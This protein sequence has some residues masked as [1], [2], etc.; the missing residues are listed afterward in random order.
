[1]TDERTLP[2]PKPSWKSGVLLTVGI[3]AGMFAVGLYRGGGQPPPAAPKVALQ[4]KGGGATNVDAIDPQAVRTRAWSKIVPQLN[5]VDELAAERIDQTVSDIN[6]FFVERKKGARPL[7]QALLGMK[8]KWQVV[9]AKLHQL[10]PRIPF[11]QQ[12]ADVAFVNEKIG[13]FIFTPDDARKAIEGSISGY[14]GQLNEMEDRLLIRIRADLS[15]REFGTASLIPALNTA[16]TLRQE[17]NALVKDLAKAASRDLGPTL[18]HELAVLVGSDV[19]A[20][21]AVRVAVAVATRLGVSAGILSAGAASSWATFGV[22]FVAA[23]MVDLSL[24]WLEKLVGYDPESAIAGKVE[25][26]LDRVRATFIDGDPEAR[27]IY[28]KLRQ[29]E[30]GQGLD[31]ARRE[32]RDA[33]NSIERSGNLGIRSELR[34]LHEGRRNLR[35]EAIRELIFGKENLT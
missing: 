16:E 5:Q 20:T 26:T 14:V 2:I 27:Q 28:L 33:A 30:N 17:Y 10:N 23:V 15:D 21:I 7:A 35:R 25:E 1:M 11:A 29:L 3:L 12:D 4:P 19:A 6:D 32:F 31:S 18:A 8:G 24:D 9:K 34:R 22:G 13:Q